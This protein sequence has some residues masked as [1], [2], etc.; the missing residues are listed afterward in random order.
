VI[1]LK[2]T[3]SFNQ[4]M[5]QTKKRIT[6]AVA[7]GIRLQ[8]PIR[9]RPRSESEKAALCRAVIHTVN[10]AKRS[11][12]LKKTDKGYVLSWKR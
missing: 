8:K 2:P 12:L 4:A 6:T 1:N 7:N 10:E 5:E 3:V 11:G 9:V